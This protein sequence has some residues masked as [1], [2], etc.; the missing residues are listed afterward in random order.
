MARL[1]I[2]HRRLSVVTGRLS[3][4]QAGYFHQQRLSLKP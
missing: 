3:V 2:G 4:G 1:I